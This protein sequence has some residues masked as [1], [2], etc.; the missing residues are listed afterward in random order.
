MAIKKENIAIYSTIN[1]NL[2]D[3]LKKIAEEKNISVSKIIKN[4][5][6][7]HLKKNGEL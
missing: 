7:E 1:R 2:N 3:E 6:I 4:L 5:I